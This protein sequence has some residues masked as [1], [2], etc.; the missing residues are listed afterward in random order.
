MFIQFEQIQEMVNDDLLGTGISTVFNSNPDK[1]REYYKIHYGLMD[2]HIHFVKKIDSL[3]NFNGATVLEIG[4]SNM[5]YELLIKQ[6]KVKKWVSLDTPW[7]GEKIS[8]IKSI[9]CRLFL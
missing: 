7:W 8:R 1:N 5:P 6:M 3:F 2:Y 9:R 4:G